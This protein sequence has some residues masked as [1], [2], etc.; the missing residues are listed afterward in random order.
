MYVVSEF[1]LQKIAAPMH[2][3]EKQFATHVARILPPKNDQKFKLH[4]IS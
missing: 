1:D 2:A 3:R 4:M